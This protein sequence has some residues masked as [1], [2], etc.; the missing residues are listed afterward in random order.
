MSPVELLLPEAPEQTIPFSVR[1]AERRVRRAT[2]EPAPA[3][4]DRRAYQRRS[5]RDLEWLRLVRIAQ[6]LDVR[7]I[8]LSEGGALL[9]VDSP[10]KP[11]TILSLEISGAGLETVVPLEVLRCYVSSL[12]GNIATYRGACAFGRLIALPGEHTDADL[13]A[14]DFVGTDAALNYLLER[15]ASRIDGSSD[16]RARLERG[17]V[18]HVLSSLHI[19][20][21]SD[22]AD[23]MSRYTAQLLGAILPALQQGLP[24]E[25][26]AAALDDRLQTFPDRWQSRLLST[27][28]RLASLIDLCATPPPP[29]VEPPV[30]Q[31]PVLSAAAPA[32]VSEIVISAPVDTAAASGF[33]KIVVR[34]VDGDIVKGYTQDFHPSR[35]QFSLWPSIHAAK[36]DRLII[37]MGRLKAVFFVRDFAGNAQYRERKTFTSRGHG[38]RLEVTFH[39]NETVVGTTLNY[40]PDGQGFFLIPVDASGNNTR[41]FV[42][43]SAVRRVRFL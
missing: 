24:K 41:I 6:G 21:S 31:L 14:N 9:E 11:G 33:Q 22:N 43:A 34:Y 36:S 37:P 19:R 5:G 30:V 13:A 35:A 2:P 29:P 12:R 39:D 26:V 32:P 18:L 38:R 23:P 17:A 4:S 42:V 1:L 3:R 40:R 15:C 8:D 25:V 28:G 10:L 27:R 16:A 20:R 7:L